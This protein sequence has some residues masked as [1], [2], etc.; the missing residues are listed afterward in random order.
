MKAINIGLIG[1]RGIGK[2]HSHSYRN[3]SAFFDINVTPIPKVLCGQDEEAAE[4]SAKAYGWE[5]WS[6]DW[7]E[8][9]QRGDI[10]LIAI[11]T[12]NYLHSRIALE[13]AKAG[14]AIICEKPLASSLSEAIEMLHAVRKHGVKHM[15]AFNFRCVPAIRLA[16]EFIHSGEIGQI[17]QWRS[18]WLAEFMD[19]DLP[20]SWLFQK[21]KAGSGALGDIG[22][23]LIDLA[24]Y[25]IGEI[26]DVNAISTTVVS[27]RVPEGGS[28]QKSLVDVD[29]AV[30]WIAQ[31]KN[32]AIGSFEAS[33][34]AGGHREE[35]DFEI[36]GSQGSLCFNCNALNELKYYSLKGDSVKNGF[37]TIFVGNKDHPYSEH[38][39][40]YGEVIGRSDVFIL[41][42][43]ELFSALEKDVNPTP[44]FYE[45][46][47]CQAV[48]EAVLESLRSK[49]W[50][51]PAYSKLAEVR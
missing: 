1:Y 26:E 8:V 46:A 36:N 40:P 16:K 23:H 25:L 37:R 4:Q 51:Q 30:Q 43:Y 9:V 17:Y 24:H 45:G 32:G 7:Q 35:F 20:L 3:V 39:C 38:I 21:D 11:C 19:H 5:E 27:E 2:V 31:F 6:T 50:T 44:G 42:A 33:R 47:Q 29:D 15:T 48:I 41:Q 22:S 12:P 13:A 10:D 28:T 34:C 49:A 14:K 18:R